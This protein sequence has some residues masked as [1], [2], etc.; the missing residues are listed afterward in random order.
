M[1]VTMEKIIDEIFI[2][3]ED[4]LNLIKENS[5]LSSKEAI[6]RGLTDWLYYDVSTVT[7]SKDNAYDIRK[8][9]KAFTPEQQ[10]IA[11]G[12]CVADISAQIE[13]EI[14]TY[15]SNKQNFAHKLYYL[16]TNDKISFSDLSD[17]P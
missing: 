7:V 2:D 10:S 5:S 17:L 16:I 1:E 9:R 14:T 8:K 15:I 6:F 3:I 13:T 4:L 12:Y 11:S